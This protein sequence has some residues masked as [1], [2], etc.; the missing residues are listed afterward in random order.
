MKRSPLPRRKKP[1]SR[2]QPPKR[3]GKPKRGGKS[4]RFAS[5]RNEAFQTWIR[6]LSCCMKIF[7]LYPV[8]C[9]HVR[10]RNAGGGDV[11]NCVPLCVRHH[12][13]FHDW[14]RHTF[15]ARH[16]IDLKVEAARYGRRWQDM[17]KDKGAA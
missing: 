13:Q 12:Q 6:G 16:Q 2:G 17:Q 7:C 8:Q 3:K 11:G 5:L 14:G 10:T 4:R 1:L 15:D 9:H